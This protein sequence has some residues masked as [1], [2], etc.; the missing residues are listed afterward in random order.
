MTA[1]KAKRSTA[2]RVTR[3]VTA[4]LPSPAPPPGKPMTKAE[5]DD[6]QRLI[7]RREGV[8]KSAAEQRSAELLA[9][10]EQQLASIYS[11]DQDEV[12]AK[13]YQAAEAATAQ[14]QAAI[15]RRCEKLGIPAKFAPS[16]GITWQGRGQNAV[17]WRQNELRR[18]A[19]SRIAAIE[20]AARVKIELQSVDLQSQVIANGLTGAARAFLD[21]MPAID[22]MMPALDV[23]K[24]ESMLESRGSREM[25]R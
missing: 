15:A 24:V 9:D 20:K 1:M 19:K 23:A 13:A 2:V 8:L 25:L 10:F 7:R 12:W 11:Y 22:T 3:P 17:A 18:V 4:P 21:T 6:L 16:V 5:R 14:A